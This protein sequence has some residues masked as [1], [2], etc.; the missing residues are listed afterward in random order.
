MIQSRH[1]NR[2]TLEKCKLFLHF[3][4]VSWEIARRYQANMRSSNNNER[5]QTLMYQVAYHTQPDDYK[6]VTL[7]IL[8]PRRL[9]LTTSFV[10]FLKNRALPAPSLQKVQCIFFIIYCSLRHSQI[11]KFNFIIYH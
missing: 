11:L 6:F 7:E 9:A 3:L 5:Q 10:L 4:Y 2:E 8:L 1:C